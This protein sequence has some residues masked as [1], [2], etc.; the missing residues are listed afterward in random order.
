MSTA[1]HLTAVKQRFH[2]CPKCCCSPVVA[3]Q[4]PC[5]V[6]LRAPHMGSRVDK[7]G[8]MV[9]PAHTQ[10]TTPHLQGK[11]RVPGHNIGMAMIMEFNSKDLYFVKHK[12]HAKA[13][14]KPCSPVRAVHLGHTGLQTERRHAMRRCH[15]ASGRTTGSPCRMHCCGCRHGQWWPTITRHKP[16]KPRY[17]HMNH[18]DACQHRKCLTPAPSDAPFS[19]LPSCL[20]RFIPGC[21]CMHPCMSSRALSLTLLSSS[22]P[23]CDHQKPS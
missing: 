2:A 15:A 12:K 23:A 14:A 16:H 13:C 18:A 9:H 21:A 6:A 11:G 22:Q 7:P 4:V 8:D 17:H 1:V 10:S 19:S 5:V 20:Y 3:G